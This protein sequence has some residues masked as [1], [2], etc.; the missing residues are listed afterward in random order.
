M[1]N[2]ITN[3]YNNILHLLFNLTQQLLSKLKTSKFYR[4]TRKA[5]QYSLLHYYYHLS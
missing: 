2:I 1:Q 3:D 5:I 4:I